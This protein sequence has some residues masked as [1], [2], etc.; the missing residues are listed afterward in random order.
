M[1]KKTVSVEQLIN[2]VEISVQAREAKF[3]G[4][5]QKPTGPFFT[6]LIG[7]GF[8]LTAGLSSVNH[9]V[10][11]LE[12]Y[13]ANRGRTW[14]EVFE[15]TLEES[16]NEKGRSYSDL[17]DYYFKIMGE[18][19]PLP[20][21]RHDFITAAI[22]WAS[23]R[24]VQMNLEGLLLAT[25]LMAGTGG[26]VP[27]HPRHRK[28]HWLSRAFARHVF[29]TNFDEVLPNT[30]YYGNQPVEILDK[31]GRSINAAAEYPTVV[32]L[33]G[34]HLHYD[35]RNTHHELHSK[36]NVPDQYD[37]FQNFRSLLRTTGLIV[38]GYSG[39]KDQVSEIILD[40]LDDPES[41]P[42]GLWWSTYPDESAIHEKMQTAIMENERAFYL[43]P[44]KDAEQILRLL[45]RGIGIDE[46][47][48]ISKWTERLRVVSQ[49]VERFLT[50]ASY[51]FRQFHL[52]ATQALLFS[53]DEMIRKALADWDMIR[54]HVL[55]HADKTFVADLLTLVAKL[56]VA[57]GDESGAEKTYNDALSLLEKIAIPDK[58]ASALTGYGELHYIL[59]DHGNA[60][61]IFKRARKWYEEADRKLGAAVARTW[62]G[63][64]F[65]A[66][67]VFDRAKKEYALSLKVCREQGYSLGIGRNLAGQAELELLKGRYEQAIRLFTEA[68]DLHRKDGNEIFIIRDLRGL[69]RVWLSM[70]DLPKAEQNLKEALE[71]A[72]TSDLKRETAH[73]LTTL[74]EALLA[75]GNRKVAQEYISKALELFGRFFDVPGSREAERVG[76]IINEK[77]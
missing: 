60:G 22:Q 23:S 40:A 37:L 71:L 16:L 43:D 15:S 54:D 70:G 2:K 53:S 67:G 21:A 45:C 32:Y 52:G 66:K 38:I 11:A 30:F 73:T 28:R 35:I 8:S 34:R 3:E 50:R 10:Q 6:F 56:M 63:E 9:L 19:L 64:V 55:D 47:P 48:A 12:Y 44:G 17:A 61:S 1:V 76:N 59:G 14:R 65:V 77:A 51:D 62:L 5:V 29:T 26:N 7:A 33:H 42:Y 46:N 4:E 49:E 31:A 75:S 68:L 24:Q 57:S 27:M 25:I 20:Q 13:R 74:A 69:G 39:A 18:V 36:Q 72:R 41:L 58:M